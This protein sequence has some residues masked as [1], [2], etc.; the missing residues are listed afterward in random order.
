MPSEKS[1]EIGH[2][3]KSDIESRWGI[4]NN[5]YHLRKGGHVAALRMHL[6][7]TSFIHLDIKN[8]FGSINRS[9]VTRCVK[10]YL[11]YKKSRYIAMESTVK[12]KDKG[13]PTFVLPF[14]FVQSPLVASL[15]FFES[16]LG[17]YLQRIMNP[18]LINVSIYMDDIIIST[19]DHNL[20]IKL[21]SEIKLAAEKSNFQL[22]A[23]KE[24]G[25]SGHITAFNIDL[26]HGQ[27]KIR[28][29]RLAEFITAYRIS[30]NPFQQM[31][32]KNYIASVNSAQSTKV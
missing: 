6:C 3:I 21:L 10:K 30:I 22:N 17:Q 32:I 13:N 4:P 28:D 27:M 20:S 8:F 7:N 24:E 18:N 5:Y 26:K 14:G 25:P 2:A 23:D 29:K 11:G 19:C 12:I 9:R 16:Y 31:G 15:C 1:I